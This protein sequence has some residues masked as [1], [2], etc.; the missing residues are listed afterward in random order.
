[1]NRL[2]AFALVI[3]VSA[4]GNVFAD[5]ITVESVPFTS[6]LT[7][8]EVMA[9]LEQFRQS[10][11]D[12]WAETYEPQVAVTSTRTRDEVTA[13]YIAARQ[14]VAARNGEDSGSMSMARHDDA[15]KPAQIA[16]L[17]AADAE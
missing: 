7:R 16:A 13:E 1:M 15:G 14:Q 11:A 2:S 3:A 9:D 10:G 5:D 12:R 6:T 4:A 17:P 8:A